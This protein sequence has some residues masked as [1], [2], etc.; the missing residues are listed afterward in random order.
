MIDIFLTPQFC[1]GNFM[2]DMLNNFILIM[3]VSPDKYLCQMVVFNFI[4]L[5]LSVPHN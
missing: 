3:S 5:P 4:L 2:I 1:C